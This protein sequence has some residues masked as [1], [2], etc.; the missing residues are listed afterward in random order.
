MH[1]R[2]AKLLSAAAAVLLA[3][4]ASTAVP[5]AALAD[6]CL[7]APNAP[8]PSGS[9]WYYRT[10]HAKQRKCWYL[11][12]VDAAP[13][14]AMP[15]GTTSADA[16]DDNA[17]TS[18]APP[19][20]VAARSKPAKAVARSA[21]ATNSA[22]LTPSIADARAE[23]VSPAEPA[24]LQG[25]S[26]VAA[27]S[28]FPAPPPVVTSAA[29]APQAA[30]PSGAAPGSDQNATIEQRWSDATT[31]G[32]PDSAPATA[33]TSKKLRKTASQLPAKNAPQGTAAIDGGT[34]GTWTLVGALMAALALAGLIVGAVVK[35]GTR[36]PTVR[37]ERRDI[38]GSVTNRPVGDLAAPV[39]DLDIG[40]DRFQPIE[41]AEPPAWIKAARERKPAA[42]PAR[43]IKAELKTTDEIEQ[44]LAL[45]QKRNAA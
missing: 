35:F 16:A 31:I 6:E 36:E 28:P 13:M 5:H 11:R 34:S 20:A 32:S 17:P 40:L 1:N 41:T 38:W 2:S 3:G 8:T 25:S 9:H 24:P 4:L 27:A 44:L 42:E 15:A 7:A 14:A 37:R 30:A 39:R 26:A 33:E 45:A 29:T 22:P 19:P 43:E 23:Y 12:K 21:P 10:D 18:E